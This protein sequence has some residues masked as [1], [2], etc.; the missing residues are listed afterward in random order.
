MT[1]DQFLRD[2]GKGTVGVIIDESPE[3]EEFCSLIEKNYFKLGASIPWSG[4]IHSY[5][6]DRINKGYKHI[7][8]DS[9]RKDRV[10]AATMPTNRTILASEL[11][12]FN[13]PVKDF[14]AVLEERSTE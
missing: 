7:M 1:P 6:L 8:C 11:E 13:S 4:S 3:F 10:T 9:G 12:W 2:F 14:L 5:A